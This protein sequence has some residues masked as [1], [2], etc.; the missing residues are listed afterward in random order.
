MG[1]WAV[2]M[3]VVLGACAPGDGIDKESTDTDVT[4]D[5]TVCG[6]DVLAPS[7]ACE[8]FELRGEDCVSQGFSG[9]RLACTDTCTLDTS[10]CGTCGDDD[11]TGPE[12]CDGTDLQ[13]TTCADVLG[14]GFAG[15]LACLPG[16]GAFDPRDCHPADQVLP[17]AAVCT[18]GGAPCGADL[19]CLDVGGV[20]LCV[21]PCTK[22]SATDGCGDGEACVDRA[23]VSV[24]IPLPATGAPCAP[25]EG[26]AEGRD[27][28]LRTG[29]DGGDD[30]W[31]CR[32]ACATPGTDVACQRGETCLPV[33]SEALE[34]EP[35]GPADCDVAKCGSGFACRDV[36]TAGVVARKCARDVLA[37]VER[38]VPFDFADPTAQQE[39]S[40]CDLGR[41][42][43]TYG[44]CGAP[45]GAGTPAPRPRCEGLVEGSED[46]G[47]CVVYCGADE[48]GET[49]DAGCGTGHGC[50]VPLEPW[51]YLPVVPAVT[52]TP[53]QVGV[54]GQDEACVDLGSGPA[55]ALPLQVC[56]P[57]VPQ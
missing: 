22:D 46:V 20:H 2:G 10:G 42:G 5:V 44:W 34:L 51:L 14:A 53:G 52:C 35:N 30:V 54:C 13:G 57:V 6:D 26:C 15:T 43:S 8:G 25:D 31:T 38:V 21:D 27:A 41:G 47:R 9:G 36:E 40:L 56:Q 24:C 11:A 33:P 1:R 19:D 48:I 37:C 7:E 39:G 28:C 4:A 12:V 50:L 29:V 45:D 32:P 55:C 18:P 23:S 16:C 49:S 17:D 3:V